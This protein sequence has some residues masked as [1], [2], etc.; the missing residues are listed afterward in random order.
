QEYYLFLRINKQYDNLF[1]NL[2]KNLFLTV[3]NK[4]PTEYMLDKKTL[5]D[6]N[7]DEQSNNYD[8]SNKEVSD[9]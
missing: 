1:K 9:N 8:T 4:L 6:D 5:V 2:S 3:L 7:F